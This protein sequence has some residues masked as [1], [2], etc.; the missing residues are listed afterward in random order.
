MTHTRRAPAAAAAVAAGAACLAAVMSLALTANVAEAMYADEVGIRDW[1]KEHLGRVT[2]A[3]FKNREV[4]G[5]TKQGAVFKMVTR[6]GKVQW[7]RV[8]PGDQSADVLL[9]NK[10]TVFTVSASSGKAYMWQATDGS[11]LWD[12]TLETGPGSDSADARYAPV[13][14]DNDGLD[15]VVVLTS[16]GVELLSSRGSGEAIWTYSAREGIQLDS[17][18]IS[19]DNVYAIGSEPGASNVVIEVLS[20]DS[21][22]HER[23]ITSKGLPSPTSG[24]DSSVFVAVTPA[25]GAQAP[26]IVYIT[27]GSANTLRSI[28]LASGTTADVS[29]DDLL[30]KAGLAGNDAVELVQPTTGGAASGPAP[31]FAIDLRDGRHL[32]AEV[33]KSGDVSVHSALQE[34]AARVFS[35]AAGMGRDAPA[36]AV[37]TATNDDGT[38][39][40]SLDVSGLSTKCEVRS[41]VTRGFQARASRSFVDAFKKRDGSLACRALVS[42]AD[43]TMHML[44][45]GKPAPLWSRDEALA[46]TD[47][48]QLVDLVTE[49]GR[50]AAET[51]SGSAPTLSYSDRVAGQ[52]SYL[53]AIPERLVSMV[54][55]IA[56]FVDDKI[57]KNTS[58][59]R[60]QLSNEQLNDFGF[61][62]VVI[63]STSA[64]KVL[65]LD[66]QTGDSL[67]T[68]QEPGLGLRRE[69]PRVYVTRE[70]QIGAA[71]P[72]ILVVTSM[73]S[74][75]SRATRLRV[76]TGQVLDSSE[77]EYA[78]SHA[79]LLPA[80]HELLARRV[81]AIFDTN[82]RVH[83][84]PDNEAGRS[85]L[86]G[87]SDSLF[88]R[89]IDE[90]AGTIRGFGVV[91]SNKLVQL[92]SVV[93]PATSRI[94]DWAAPPGT[95]VVHS[96]AHTQGND[97]L[98]MKY[99]NPHLIAVATLEQKELGAADDIL[100]VTLIDTVTGRIVRTYK[101]R[102]ATTPV[103]LVRSENWAFCS[104][105]NQGAQRTEIWSLS[106]YEGEVD[107]DAL[108]PWSSLPDAV[109]QDENGVAGTFSSFASNDPVALQK[110][111]IF[112]QGISALA[113]TQT[114]RGITNKFLLVG[115]MNEQILVLDRRALDPRRPSE[116]PSDADKKEGLMQFFPILQ[117]PATMVLSYSQHVAKLSQIISS[118]TEL[119]STTLVVGVGLDMFFTRAAPARAF[120][121]MPD[122]F[123]YGLLL[124]ISVGLV[125]GV[126]WVSRAVKKKQLKTMWR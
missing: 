53:M 38:T 10:H 103:H 14:L 83:A 113:T 66:S 7:R 62:K 22:A 60:S 98:L 72:E 13:D 35:Y 80:R 120:D 108:N 18:C 68:F 116:A 119:E 105:W 28:D 97:G 102:D 90:Q 46:D 49:L 1:M 36:F 58:R 41:S 32:V 125:F 48:V 112:P 99:L 94:V 122:D 100:I 81:L 73:G 39:V 101:H 33:S 8:L 21:G 69:A 78:V 117:Y 64:G 50:D 87:A 19:D 45:S 115:M 118:P 27:S 47:S 17:L 12:T 37:V 71:T 93:F 2:Q 104:Y 126:S 89:R 84:I 70:K 55:M 29:V 43:D 121:V 34:R 25:D 114:K 16:N 76:S 4:F 74:D 40:S 92:W 63:A 65:A 123:N 86:K 15:D 44:Q 75:R 57:N 111:F 9:L 85:V 54:S 77:L 3:A 5:A 88:I 26:V 52:L 59:R 42:L 106:L 51:D 110:S 11:L 67:W 91:G 96:P 24:T 6:T 95:E 109:T 23:T 30:A 61:R 82:D 31:F 79:V 20:L 107:P 56:S 124:L